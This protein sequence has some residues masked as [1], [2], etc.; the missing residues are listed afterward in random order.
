MSTKPRPPQHSIAR[1]FEATIP[2]IYNSPKGLLR[3]FIPC[4]PQRLI[5]VPL[6]RVIERDSFSIRCNARRDVS[7]KNFVTL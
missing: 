4:W 5:G 3:K 6:Q 1:L 2:A 7:R